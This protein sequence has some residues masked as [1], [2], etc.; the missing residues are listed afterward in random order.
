MVELTKRVA[1]LEGRTAVAGKM[2]GL[3]LG[4]VEASD[5]STKK[6][7]MFAERMEAE[8]QKR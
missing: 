5:L 3:E 1:G 6:E 4:W 8:V 2:E 7:Q